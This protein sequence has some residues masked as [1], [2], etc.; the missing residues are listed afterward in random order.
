MLH[1]VR[2]QPRTKL[3]AKSIGSKQTILVVDDEHMSDLMRSVFRQLESEGFN[4][5]AIVP[6][7]PRVTGDD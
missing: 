2:Q 6:D 1:D 7:G 5:I 4:P 3:T